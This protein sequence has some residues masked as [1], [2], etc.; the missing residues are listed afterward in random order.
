METRRQHMRRLSYDDGRPGSVIAAT[1]NLS[2]R[3][4]WMRLPFAASTKRDRRIRL[5]R[6]STM[7]IPSRPT[8]AETPAIGVGALLFSSP[9]GILQL[10]DSANNSSYYT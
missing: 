6:W 3:S 4:G 7:Q 10:E 9:F 2:H 8:M 5:Q 1:E